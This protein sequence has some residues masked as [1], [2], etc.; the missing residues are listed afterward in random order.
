VTNFEFLYEPFYVAPDTVPGHDER[1]VGYGF[2][3]NTQVSFERGTAE[4]E[5]YVLKQSYIEDEAL[6]MK[7]PSDDVIKIDT[8]VKNETTAP[9]LTS[10]MVISQVAHW[11]LEKF[12]F[13]PLNFHL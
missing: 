9:G 12:D 3:R 10:V 7:L 5:G 4:E 13:P 1:F 2:T 11:G 6:W 8:V